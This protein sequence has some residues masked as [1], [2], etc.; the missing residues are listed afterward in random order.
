MSLLSKEETNFAIL[1]NNFIQSDTYW[2]PIRQAVT[3]HFEAHGLPDTPDSA[4]SK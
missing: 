3:A 1:V 2:N 4:P